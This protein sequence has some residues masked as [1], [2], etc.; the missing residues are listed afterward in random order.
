[1]YSQTMTVDDAHIDFQDV[2]DGLYYPFYMET[3][4]HAFMKE[5][6][7]VDLQQD[8]AEGKFHMLLEYTIKF[9]K[10]LQRGDTF[11]VTC[12]PGFHEKK[13]RVVFNQ[14]I[15][16]DGAVYAEADFVATCLINGRPAIPDSFSAVIEAAQSEA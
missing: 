14:K 2:V 1:M 3:V 6:A 15:I 7:G 10:S 11:V 9:K 5:V 16:K 8:A 4:R 12:V 13:N